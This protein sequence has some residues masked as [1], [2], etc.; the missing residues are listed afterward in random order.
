MLRVESKAPDR[1]WSG[2]RRALA[3]ALLLAVA[4]GASMLH[5]P[6]RADDPDGISASGSKHVPGT[7]TD[8]GTVASQ[9][10]PSTCRTSPMTTRRPSWHSGP[11]L[12]SVARAWAS[13]ARH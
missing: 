4:A 9:S 5:G 6:A 1:P 7:Y 8:A 12:R 11:R 13:T 10:S 3:A 2:L